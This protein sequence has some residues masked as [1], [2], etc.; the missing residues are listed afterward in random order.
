VAPV[1]HTFRDRGDVSAEKL[2]DC[3]AVKWDDL[4]VSGLEVAKGASAP[5]LAA[6]GPS[7][8]LLVNRFD[9]AGTME[10]VFFAIQMPHSMLFSSTMELRPH[11]HWSPTSEASGNVKWS[12]EYSWSNINDIFYA[13]TTIS[14]V[15][16]A[17]GT[18]W[19]HKIAGFPYITGTGKSLSS[20][21][22]CRLYRDPTDAAD[23]YGADAAFIEFDFHV[24]FDSRGSDEEYTKS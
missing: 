18:A 23:T 24:Q 2:N 20:M 11:I 5:D 14:V 6:F 19:R 22:V 7:G 4:R 15:D 1:K 9:G 3:L 8:N 17:G 10:Q 13:P 16:D 21:I 12:L